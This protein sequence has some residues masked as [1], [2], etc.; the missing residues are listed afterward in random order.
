METEFY[1]IVK[2]NLIRFMEGEEINYISD[3]KEFKDVNPIKAREQAFGYYNSY[4]DT[5]LDS[6]L[7]HNEVRVL[8]APR[9]KGAD[10]P[11][12]Y[13]NISEEDDIYVPKSFFHGIG[14]F[15]KA[16]NSDENTSL[17]HGVGFGI[18]GTPISIMDG[19]NREIWWYN[20][21]NYDKGDYEISVR[22]YNCEDDEIYDDIILKTPYDWTGMD[23]PRE[24]DR[25]DIDES[26]VEQNNLSSKIIAKVLIEKGEGRMIE[27]K[28]SLQSYVRDGKVH[29]GKFNRFEIVRTIAAFLNSKDGG[30]LLVGVGDDRQ[31]LGLENDFQL[32]GDSSKDPK[33]YFKIQVDYIIKNN[34]KSMASNIIGNFVK[35]EDRDIFVFK[36]RPSSKPIFIVNDTEGDRSAHKKEFYVRLTGASS[37]HYYDI[38]DIVGYCM[39]RWK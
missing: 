17:V 7:S 3:E 9:I 38:E 6:N 18:F 24:E 16:N 36:I 2:V 15:L 11:F 39:N 21:N 13:E 35:L 22:F 27:F 28:P 37:I 5:L 29:F 14:V 23:E 33:D 26:E 1:Y 30:F 25:A 19:L 12:D 31:V 10:K 32:S 34:F 4:I 8:L 20:E